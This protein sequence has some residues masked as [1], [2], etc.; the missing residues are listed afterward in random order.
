MCR[1]PF[2]FN[3]ATMAR[4]PVA[5]ACC[6]GAFAA[7]GCQADTAETPPRRKIGRPIMDTTDPDSQ[8]LT[9]AER[10][11]IKRCVIATRRPSLFSS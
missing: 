2:F 3:S 8:D 9:E 5:E 10:R 4:K 6:A 11:R 7:A 1:L